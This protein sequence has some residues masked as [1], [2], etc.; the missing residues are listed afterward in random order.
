MKKYYY[1]EETRELDAIE[2]VEDVDFSGKNSIALK[3]ALLVVLCIGWGFL[4]L[5]GF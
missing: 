5:W 1:E 3:V 4:A 2:I